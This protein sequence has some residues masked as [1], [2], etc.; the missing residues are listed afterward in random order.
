MRKL[1]L[2]SAI[3]Q[4]FMLVG[5]AQ[6]QEYRFTLI[7]QG[8]TDAGLHKIRIATEVNDGNNETVRW[9]AISTGLIT[10]GQNVSMAMIQQDSIG[11][12][13]PYKQLLVDDH[14]KALWQRM[15]EQYLKR[16]DQLERNDPMLNQEENTTSNQ[17][18]KDE[19]IINI[20]IKAGKEE[21]EAYIYIAAA[22]NS[23][24]ICMNKNLRIFAGNYIEINTQFF[25]A[26]TYWVYVHTGAV[27]FSK[28]ILVY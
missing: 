25:P 4:F 17:I 13:I 27:S 19:K 9:R 14:F 8:K 24:T 28:K 1:L 23:R 2:L 26:G 21:K 11:T 6:V 22:D 12:L 16:M 5:S 7:A 15:L 20:S 18:W 10:T 3:F